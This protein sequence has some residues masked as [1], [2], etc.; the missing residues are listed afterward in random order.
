MQIIIIITNDLQQCLTEEKRPNA[1]HSRDAPRWGVMR[2]KG[3][4]TKILQLIV[5]HQKKIKMYVATHRNKK[6][7]K[8]KQIYRQSNTILSWKCLQFAVCRFHLSKTETLWIVNAFGC[9]A[10]NDL[11]A[12]FDVVSNMHLCRFPVYP[13][14]SMTIYMK[15]IQTLGVQYSAYTLYS[16]EMLG[17]M[18]KKTENDLATYN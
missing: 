18:K 3:K 16:I 8:L 4:S 7:E 2:K 17:L 13:I 11:S 6:L 10:S 12:D 15:K 14:W 5:P 9:S 1:P